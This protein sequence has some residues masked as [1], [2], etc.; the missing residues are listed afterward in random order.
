MTVCKFYASGNCRYGNNCNF[1]HTG[2]QQN[3]WGSNA[4]PTAATSKYN[5]SSLKTDLTEARPQWKLSVYGPAKEEPNL[6]VGTDRSCEED[7][8]LYYTSMRTTNNT[9]QYASIQ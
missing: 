3:R 5:E 6:I 4:T 9:T 7:R 8:Y 2:P 1:E